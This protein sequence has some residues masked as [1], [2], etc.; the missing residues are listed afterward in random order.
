MIIHG[1]EPDRGTNWCLFTG[2]KMPKSSKF[3][4]ILAQRVLNLE[5]LESIQCEYGTNDP[6]KWSCLVGKPS[7]V[8]GL[9][10]VLF[11]HILSIIISIDFHIFHSVWNHQPD[12]FWALMIL[13][14]VNIW[15]LRVSSF[16]ASENGPGDDQL[17]WIAM[18]RSSN[19]IPESIHKS[20]PIN[21]ICIYIYICISY[22][23]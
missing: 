1:L 13:H 9:E 3:I 6:Q 22:I 20:Y 14:N 19:D 10:H 4:Q 16:C 15:R 17:Q 8:G 18:V 11:F 2:P 12:P 21:D 5:F 7:L 23:I